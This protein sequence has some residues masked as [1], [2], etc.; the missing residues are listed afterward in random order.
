M[1][2]VRRVTFFGTINHGLVAGGGARRGHT[3]LDGGVEGGRLSALAAKV[4]AL[5]SYGR[6]AVEDTVLGAAGD[7]GQ[8]D[9]DAVLCDG[10]TARDECER[11]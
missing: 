9:V 8:G 4:C 3:T 11:V 10:D 2:N 1:H 6:C 7:G 5:A